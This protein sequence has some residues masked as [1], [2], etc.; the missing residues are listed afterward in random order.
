MG[1]LNFRTVRGNAVLNEVFSTCDFLGCFSSSIV[2][3]YLLLETQDDLLP[4]QRYL[5]TRTEHPATQ[6]NVYNYMK[7]SIGNHNKLSRFPTRSRD[8]TNLVLSSGEHS[9]VWRNSDKARKN[10][11]TLS[12]GL[13]WKSRLWRA[14]EES[15]TSPVVAMRLCYGTSPWLKSGSS[16]KPQASL[17]LCRFFSNYRTPCVS[18]NKAHP[19]QKR[20]KF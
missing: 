19:F 11:W 15:A 17:R 9:T 12:S 7:F 13:R 20:T 2:L 6:I 4:A 16:D 5:L 18:L 10:C 3:P 14:S 8:K 1:V